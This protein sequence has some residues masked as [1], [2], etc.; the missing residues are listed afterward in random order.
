MTSFFRLFFE[1]LGD[2]MLIILMVLA[3]ISIVLGVAFPDR[4]EDR[5]F[6]WIEGAAIIIAVFIIS[7][8]TAVNDY[9]KELKF[10]ELSKQNNQFQVKVVRKGENC[11][12]TVD[13]VLVGD[14][15]LLDTGDQIP[16]DGILLEG[17]DLRIDE[18]VMTGEPV[19]VKKEED[20]PFLL[21]GCQVA[22]GCGKMIVTAVGMNSEWGKTLAKLNVEVDSQTPL[23]ERL[24][25][26]AK[27]ISKSGVFFGVS[28]FLILLVGWLI[29]K[30]K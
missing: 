12:I 1:A 20:N 29:M 9:Q 3:V 21:S 5:K 13:E 2:T 25:N 18:S 28:T 10:R 7:T 16:A 22:E 11:S 27:I 24:E 19:A 26:L 15:V 23:E 17:F 30:S 8:V 6:G 14:V 4:P